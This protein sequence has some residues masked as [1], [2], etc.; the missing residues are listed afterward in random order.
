M[1]VMPEVPERD[2]RESQDAE[3]GD[4]FNAQLLRVQNGARMP[5][6]NNMKWAMVPTPWME[7]WRLYCSSRGQAP[8][9]P[10]LDC[11]SLIDAAANSDVT[12]KDSLI[13]VRREL[14]EGPDFTF[15]PQ[16]E[17]NYLA[18]KYGSV[19]PPVL[20]SVV[21]PSSTASSGSGI[22][23]QQLFL[24][25]FPRLVR[26]TDTEARQLRVTCLSRST[27]VLAVIEGLAD[28][29]RVFAC[30][31]ALSAVELLPLGRGPQKMTPDLTDVVAL[32]GQTWRLLRDV[33]GTTIGELLSLVGEGEGEVQ[34][35]LDSP[36]SVLDAPLY[37]WQSLLVAGD[38]L[39]CS[40]V[41]GAW[42]EARVVAVQSASVTVHYKGWEATHDDDVPLGQARLQPLH[43]QEGT[44]WR[45]EL[46]TRGA[47]VD[48]RTAT[49][50]WWYVCVGLY[51]SHSHHCYYC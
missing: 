36:G 42:F 4:D 21:R 33:K 44:C 50:A 7:G 8:R 25:T 27:T 29:G 40:D 47:L 10:P 37:R 5:L 12:S 46:R 15:L 48:L 49:N 16:T 11:T 43:T 24:E 32:R 23:V 19:C 51:S 41:K 39:D 26:V 45:D 6:V 9:P 38:E 18:G 13:P 22:V 30:V 34:L 3:V 17:F 14:Q 1:M 35:L 20:R 2:A 28:S 31:P